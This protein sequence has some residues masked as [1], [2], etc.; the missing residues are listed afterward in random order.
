[1]ALHG[2]TLN[3]ERG[4]LVS[5]V[6]ANGAGKSTLMKVIMGLVPAASRDRRVRGPIAARHAHP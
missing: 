4:E 1:M 5:L 6:G 2:V 3:V